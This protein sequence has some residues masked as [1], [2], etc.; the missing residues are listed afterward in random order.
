MVND[1]DVSKEDE[2]DVERED[3]REGSPPSMLQEDFRPRCW[4]VEE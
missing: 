4:W 1:A 3:C 2:R